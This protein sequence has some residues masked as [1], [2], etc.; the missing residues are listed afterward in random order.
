MCSNESNALKFLEKDELWFLIFLILKGGALLHQEFAFCEKYC[1]YV[2]SS[3]YDTA[4]H[5]PAKRKSSLPY[6][7]CSRPCPTYYFIQIS[8]IFAASL[9]LA[10]CYSHG[11]NLFSFYAHFKTRITFKSNGLHLFWRNQ[12]VFRKMYM[13]DSIS[14][15]STLN[16]TEK[17]NSSNDNLWSMFLFFWNMYMILEY[18]WVVDCAFWNWVD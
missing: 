8:H 18:F 14:K 2:L 6:Q 1:A 4:S 15:R 16:F 11:Q 13:T 12:T 5:S 3:P 7:K 17:T 10:I 9:L